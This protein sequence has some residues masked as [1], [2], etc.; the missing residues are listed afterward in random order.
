M[1]KVVRLTESDLIKIV[2]RVIQED[3][4][5]TFGDKVKNTIRGA[6]GLRQPTDDEERLADDIMTAV[7]NG[8]FEVVKT[9]HAMA[10]PQYVLSHTI[11]LNL[12]DGTYIV[13]PYES[14]HYG[15]N[16]EVTPPRGPKLRLGQSGF[17]KKLMK[18]I[19]NSDR[20]DRFRYPR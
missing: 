10:G 18:L 8:D 14:I 19:K 12:K 7:E 6:V 9:H 11:K 5:F 1:K 3:A 2:K 13:H 20:G 4:G 16:T 17:T 15:Y